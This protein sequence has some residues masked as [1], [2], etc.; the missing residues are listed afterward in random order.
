MVAGVVRA[1]LPSPAFSLEWMH[2]IEHTRW[3]EHY[4]VRGDR[5]EVTSARIEGMGAGMDPGPNARFDGSGWTWKPALAP[6][7]EFALTLSPYAE[8]YRLCAGARC[9]SLYQW[10]G[11]APGTTAI[12]VIRPC[13]AAKS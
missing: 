7:A 13:G 8:D 9:R 11:V 6:L 10:T 12:V 4:R 5:I 1:A 2:S 3:E